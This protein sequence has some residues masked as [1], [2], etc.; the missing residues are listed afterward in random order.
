MDHMLTDS[1][2]SFYQAVRRCWRFG[3]RR[4]VHIHMVSASTEGNVLENLKRKDEE[5]AEMAEEMATPSKAVRDFEYK[6]RLKWA[7]EKA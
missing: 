6:L 1:W 5:A 4:P 3:Q 7:A 2:E